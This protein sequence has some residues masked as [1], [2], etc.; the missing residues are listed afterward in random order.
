MASRNLFLSLCLILT[1]LLLG[2]FAMPWLLWAYNVERAGPLLEQGL[3]WPEPRQVDSVPQ[4]GNAE[5]LDEALA[6]L[7]AAIRWRSDHPYAYRL[8][9]HIYMARAD[10]ARAA[11]GLEHARQYAPLDPLVGWEAGLAY[12]HL[13]QLSEQVPYEPLLPRLVRAKIVAP[14]QPL[15]T[16]FCKPGRPASCY[17]GET[18]FVQSYA[19]FPEE[20]GL[21][22][23]TLFQH[24]PS[25]IRL[26]LTLPSGQP[27]I[28]FLMGLD[29]MA[30]EW[31]SDGAIFQV[32][33]E[34]TAGD[35]ILLYEKE[36]DAQMAQQGWFPGWADL[37]PWTGQRVTLVFGTAAGPAG[38]AIADWYGW[39][40]V[41]LTTTE[42]AQYR[43]LLPRL[44]MRQAWR[45]AQ[46]SPGHF[47][48]RAAQAAKTP[49]IKARWDA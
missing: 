26:P 17:V 15:D 23:P 10:W 7:A 4:V 12:E 34:P 5:A 11:E 45:A 19:D 32:W 40:D 42:G 38:N 8:A 27:A 14:E 29:P 47:A 35:T 20:P 22:T 48:G 28:S 33:V 21:P 36:M 1:L 2:Y 24:A 16:P 3:A 46:L 44:R 9:A 43:V 30:R 49:E 13:W 39:G 18:S 37:S 31:G 25:Q 41:M 6:H